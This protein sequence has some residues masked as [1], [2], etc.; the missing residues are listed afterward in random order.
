MIASRLGFRWNRTAIL[1]LQ[2]MVEDYMEKVFED[3]MLVVAHAQGN[4]NGK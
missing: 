1:V 2:E 4:T 3:A